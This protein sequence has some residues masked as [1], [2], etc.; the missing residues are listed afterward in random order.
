MAYTTVNPILAPSPGAGRAG[1][2]REGGGEERPAA[3]GTLHSW[4]SEHILPRK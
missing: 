3:M 2:E 4:M 1:G